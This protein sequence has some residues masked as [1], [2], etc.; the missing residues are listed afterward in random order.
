MV[1]TIIAIA[2]LC[3][4][5][6]T[7][8][9]TIFHRGTVKCTRPTFIAFLYDFV[10]KS[11]PQA[12]I[13][14]RALLYSTGKRGLVIESLFLRVREGERF[15]EFSFWGYGD[16]ELVRGSGLFVGEA[17]QV[18]NHHFNPINSEKL[19]RFSPGEYNIELVAKVVGRNHLVK[20]AQITLNL[21]S[22]LLTNDLPSR[23]TAVYF[24][25][26]PE[27]KKYIAS[28]ERHETG[29]FLKGL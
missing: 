28:V 11:Q 18:T 27:Q 23:Q 24:N 6:F 25:W 2:S 15:E 16:K 29:M 13:F 4:S 20:L 5:L 21:P 26:S 1:S 10:Q 14:L 17:G 3:I 22:G 7:A 12:K 9:F 19:F 8:W